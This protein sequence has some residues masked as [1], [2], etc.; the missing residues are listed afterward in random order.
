[1]HDKKSIAQKGEKNGDKKN[2]LI[3]S[4]GREYR[5]KQMKLL[6]SK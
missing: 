4:Y 2:F 1:M 5:Y 6:V 3:N